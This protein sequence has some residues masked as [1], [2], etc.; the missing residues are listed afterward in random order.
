[1]F[2][3]VTPDTPFNVSLNDR[4]A[5][6]IGNVSVTEGDS[7]TTPAT[8]AVSLSAPSSDPVTL[9]YATA[10]GT[11]TAGTDYQATSGTLSFSPGQTTLYVSVPVL[12]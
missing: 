9:S 3:Q 11:A 10:D 1:M 5:A 4:M 12:N 7:G 2:S 6:S 8:F